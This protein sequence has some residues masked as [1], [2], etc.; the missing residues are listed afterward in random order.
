M[1]T[2]FVIDAGANVE[3]GMPSGSELKTKIINFFL[4]LKMSAI[5]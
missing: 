3:I 5:L 1:R 2:V 4:M